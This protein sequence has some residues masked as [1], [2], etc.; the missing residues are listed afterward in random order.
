MTSLRSHSKST[1]VDQA[2]TQ[3]VTPGLI[4][5]EKRVCL[6]PE[7][8]GSGGSEGL[9]LAAWWSWKRGAGKCEGCL[10]RMSGRERLSSRRSLL[11]RP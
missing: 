7:A 8:V 6:G 4:V 5:S 3:E 11:L 1:E 10:P 9:G 2:G